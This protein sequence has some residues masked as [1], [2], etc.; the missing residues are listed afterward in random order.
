MSGSEN[1]RGAAPRRAGLRR[2]EM[3]RTA[4]VAG[5]AAAAGALAAPYVGNAQT[6]AGISLKVQTVWSAGGVGQQI[7][8]TWCHSMIERT[9]GELALV[10]FAADDI[11]GIFEMMDAVA[12][13]VLDGMHWFPPYWGTTGRMPAGFFLTSIPMG[14]D[15]PHQCGTCCST[16]MAA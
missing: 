7:F 16:A 11:S 6:A 4:A 3:L 5:G 1:E 14:L 12:G 9:S 10:P 8:E 2:R 13:G 15:Q